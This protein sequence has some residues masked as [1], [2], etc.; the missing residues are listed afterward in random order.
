MVRHSLLTTLPR[1]PPHLA[2]RV[3][4]EFSIR[5]WKRGD[6]TLAQAAH[7]M[8][9][10]LCAPAVRIDEAAIAALPNT[11]RVIGTFSVGFDHIDV[12][13]ARARGIAVVNTPGV[14]SEATAEFTMLL[15]LAAARRSG[16]A[17]RTLRAGI[18]LGPSP[19][20]FQGVQ[21]SGKALGILGM[22][23]IGQALADMARGFGM[24]IHYRNRTRLPLALEKGA[25]H[26]TTDGS[27][28]RACHLLAICAPATPDTHLW[29]NAE[30]IALLPPGAIVVNTAR[31]SLVDDAALVAALRT[32]HIRAAGLDVFPHEPAVPEAY[33]A[34]E[35][36]VLTPHIASATDE[37][38]EGMA[39]LVLD[40]ITAVLAGQVPANRL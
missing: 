26:H 3:A 6:E 5:P 16:E 29:L 23:R 8:D 15:L 30:R 20:Q 32:G 37:A 38:R 13:A 36:V 1:L 22:G 4:A 7:G 25:T 9:G 33:L 31:G 28:L 19:E 40:G 18:W 21:V 17:E 24:A 35:N 11:L 14:L 2:R 12:E 10:I 27:F 39:N 34:L